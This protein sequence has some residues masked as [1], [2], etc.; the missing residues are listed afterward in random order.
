MHCPDCSGQLTSILYEGVDINQCSKCK[1]ILLDEQKLNKIE[2]SR[3]ETISRKIK[4]NKS[5][6]HESSLSCPTCNIQMQKSKYGKYTPKT[7]DKCPQCNNIWLD[8]GELEDIQVA[9]EMYEDN[10]NKGKKVKNE[11]EK[12]SLIVS[13]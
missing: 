9:H 8:E 7:I 4:H 1:G 12:V 5:R 11:N 6:S 2:T 13:S 10:I 3:E